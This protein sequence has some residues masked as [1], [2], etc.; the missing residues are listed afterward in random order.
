[1]LFRS[2]LRFVQPDAADDRLLLVNLGATFQQ[3]SVPEPRIAPPRGMRWRL[4]WSSEDP[5]YG[6]HGTPPPFTEQGLAIPGRAAL[7]FAPEH[8]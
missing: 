6:G 3:A 7:A 2:C 8:P 4:I 1:M 5:R